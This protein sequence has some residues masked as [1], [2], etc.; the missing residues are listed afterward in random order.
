ML[1]K[2]KDYPN[3][4]ADLVPV[5]RTKD[6]AEFTSP[7]DAIAYTEEDDKSKKIIAFLNE[8]KI[9]SDVNDVLLGSDGQLSGDYE[10]YAIKDEVMLS[11]WIEGILYMTPEIYKD[12]VQIQYEQIK[13]TATYPCFV[14]YCRK[15]SDIVSQEDLLYRA[16]RMNEL[17]N[18]LYSV[19]MSKVEEF[20][21]YINAG[22]A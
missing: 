1:Y 16:N 17:Y 5:Y 20:D 15:L 10:F 8:I 6:G 18:K 21:T 4:V 22:R 12:F 14:G 11:I 7:E 2:G 13:D 3:I 19:T 9:K